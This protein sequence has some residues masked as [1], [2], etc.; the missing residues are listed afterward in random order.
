MTRSLH[1]LSSANR[2]A[3]AALFLSAVS[4]IL[5]GSCADRE[6]AQSRD[7]ASEARVLRRGLG[8]QPGS[9]DPQRAEDA[10]SYDVLRD[11]YEG[12]V[13]SSPDGEVVPAVAE[14]WEVS[15]DGMV[16]TFRLRG[17]ARW[18]N[19]DPVVAQQ[20][21]AALRRAVDPAT[22]SGAADLL[23]V[24]ENAPAILR[25]ELPPER[26]AVSAVDEHT[27]VIRLSRPVAYFPDILTNTVASPLH[28]S[29]LTGNGFSSPG[30]TATNG[31]YRLVALAPGANLRLNRNPHYWDAASVAYDEVRYE[32][33]PDENAEYTRF[34]A[35]E[36]DVTN[37][38]PEQRFAELASNAASGLQHRAWLATFYFTFNTARGPLRDRPG[39]RQA[40]S[41]AVD[42]EA[43]GTSIARAGQVPAY[44]LVP[45]GIWNYK[46]SRYEW[47]RAPQ[48]ERLAR[49][50]SLYAAAGFAPQRP[51][52]LRLLYNENELVQRVS[53]AI[54]AMWKEALG[55]EVELIQMEFK[56]YLS[57]RADPEQWDVV[58]VGWTADYNDA[59]SFLDT[60]LEGSPQNFGRWH[61]PDYTRLLESAANETDA[62]R[63]RETLQRAEALMLQDYPLLPVYFYVTRRLVQPQVQAPPINPMNRTYS[64][65]FRPAA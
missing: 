59:S 48:D 45:D 62:A 26:L 38:V 4:A 17:N 56:A 30:K 14:S 39:L 58:R 18:S 2:S 37:S 24:I 28:P 34:R 40:L 27:L 41:L 32:F 7:P 57:A 9:L 36:L 52:R 3:F 43:I 42:R 33:M 35:G 54:A 15:A 11:L 44:S 31:P 63:R 12:L 64:R 20:F 16:Y 53:L 8:G 25:G 19:K 10:F 61:D 60:M 1:F 49:A 22:A 13:A 21:V 6:S 46:P 47:S 50:R 29:S 51:L 55:V 65:Y 5:L 23:R